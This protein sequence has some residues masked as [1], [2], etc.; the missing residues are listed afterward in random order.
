M[1]IDVQHDHRMNLTA[2]AIFA[3]QDKN[4]VPRTFGGDVYWNLGT[5]Y[6]GYWCL[7]FLSN[8]P[9]YHS[10]IMFSVGRHL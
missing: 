8:I 3:V 6:Q 4:N 9:R 10:T 7:K 5:V 1:N 2:V